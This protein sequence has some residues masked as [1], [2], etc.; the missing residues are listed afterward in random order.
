MDAQERIHKA[1]KRIIKAE[2]KQ[3]LAFIIMI[4]AGIINIVIIFYLLFN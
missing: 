1:E 3:D 2:E 4:I